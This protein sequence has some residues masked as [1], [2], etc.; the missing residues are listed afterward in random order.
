MDRYSWMIHPEARK[1]LD[2]SGLTKRIERADKNRKLDHLG[3]VYERDVVDCIKGMSE[4][5]L[6]EMIPEEERKKFKADLNDLFRDR[7]SASWQIKRLDETQKEK[8]EPV[9]FLLLSGYRSGSLLKAPE[10]FDY[11]KFGFSSIFEFTGLS[12]QQ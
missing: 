12:A 7:D 9:D 4:D 3:V 5:H 10:L 8:V 2:D 6:F 11:K 1:K